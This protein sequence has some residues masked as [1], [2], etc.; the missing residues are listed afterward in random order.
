MA[1]AQVVAL[2]A[3]QTNGKDVSRD[4]AYPAQL[5]A[6]LRARGRSAQVVNAGVDGDT[7]R[8][9]LSR[10]DSAVPPGTKVVILQPGTNAVDPGAV[11]QIRARLAA[12]GVRVIMFEGARRLVP[13]G[14]VQADGQHLTPEGY[15]VVASQLLP[16]VLRALG[17]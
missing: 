10:L 11:S 5:E 6:M 16:Q 1:Q 8:G 15:R 2:G 3:S 17:P 9:M 13:A 7:P 12:R 4:Q 14:D